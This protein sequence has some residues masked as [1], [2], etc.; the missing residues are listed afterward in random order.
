MPGNIWP[1]AFWHKAPT[2]PP[3]KVTPNGPRDIPILQNRRDNATPWQGALG[4]GRALGSR[5]GFVGT[6]NGG[7][8]VYGT[9]SACAD[10]ASVAFLAR[11]TLPAKPEYCSGPHGLSTAVS[12]RAR[13][14]PQGRGERRRAGRR[15]GAPLVQPPAETSPS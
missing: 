13:P 9:G 6:G 11:G 7:H 14:G 15:Y 5:A 1:C 12:P 10:Q 8:Y 3:V 2:G 4:M